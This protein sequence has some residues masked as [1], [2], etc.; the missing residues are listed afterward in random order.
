MS[1]MEFIIEIGS[2]HYACESR[3]NLTALEAANIV[4]L[5]VAK[6]AY[7]GLQRELRI[8]RPDD[9][10]VFAPGEQVHFRKTRCNYLLS[11]ATFTVE[12]LTSRVPQDNWAAEQQL[13]VADDDDPGLWEAE[14]YYWV[15]GTEE[16]NWDEL[17]A[18]QQGVAS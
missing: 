16:K 17:G 8:H 1:N 18:S 3:R 2:L 5:E 15:E 9:L 12:Q 13:V 11:Q 14:D 10:P 7:A 6:F 4:D